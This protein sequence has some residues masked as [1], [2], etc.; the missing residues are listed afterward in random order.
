MKLQKCHIYGKMFFIEVLDGE[1]FVNEVL[2][3]TPL[4]CVRDSLLEEFNRN[5]KIVMVP[6]GAKRYDENM[7]LIHDL[8]SFLCK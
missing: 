2:D 8:H 3:N 7:N 5:P 4:K 6:K 1:D